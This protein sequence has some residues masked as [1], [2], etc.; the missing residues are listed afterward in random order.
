MLPDP[1][2]AWLE[3]YAS[4]IFPSF[5]YFTLLFAWVPQAL[6]FNKADRRKSSKTLKNI[7]QQQFWATKKL[8]SENFSHIFD[9]DELDIRELI[10]STLRYLARH[11]LCPYASFCFAFLARPVLFSSVVNFTTYVLDLF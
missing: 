1:R 5:T 7:S 4:L 8:V 2:V 11:L 10:I 3:G 6:L 9:F